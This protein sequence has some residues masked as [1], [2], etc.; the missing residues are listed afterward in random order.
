M[1]ALRRSMKVVYLVSHRALADQ[2][3]LDFNERIGEGAKDPLAHVALST[4][5]RSEG[6]VD[7]EVRVT[8]YEKAIG[9]LLSGQ[10][11]AENLLVIA[12]EL[13]ILCDASRGPH[14]ETLCAILKQRHVKQFIALTAT[15][16]N[17]EDLAGWLECQLVK[18][19]VRSAP[20]HQEIWAQG[21]VYC[22]TFGQETGS[23]QACPIRSQDVNEVVTYLL[24]KGRGPI[25]VFTET[26]KEASR[27]AEDFT[28]NR[29]RTTSGVELAQQL[30]LF[31]EPT[32]SSDKLKSFA[33][34]CVAFTPL[35]CRRRNAKSSKKD[36]PNHAL[37]SVLQPRH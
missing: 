2:K 6:N 35:I 1:A 13:Q 19:S 15:V 12:D 5:D 29:V 26:R 11:R 18:S 22:V 32:E 16:E 27:Y 10:I 9:L 31:S 21:R 17:P 37:K 3:F 28:G 25:L 33:E 30:D 20:L 36:L 34:K 14:I 7:A 4:G 23:E 8:T 24:K